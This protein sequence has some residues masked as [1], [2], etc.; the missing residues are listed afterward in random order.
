MHD[1]LQ[2][3]QGLL[4]SI[5][6][7]L[8]EKDKVVALMSD[9]RDLKIQIAKVNLFLKFVSQLK[10]KK[11]RFVSHLAITTT[12]QYISQMRKMNQSHTAAP[13]TSGS[14]ELHLPGEFEVQV[15]AHLTLVQLQAF[16]QDVERCLRSLDCSAD[17]NNQS[18][19]KIVV[20]FFWP[21]LKT[22][23]AG[24]CYIYWSAIYL[25]NLFLFIYL[26]LE[27]DCIYLGN[28]FFWK[29]FALVRHMTSY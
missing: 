12:S 3:H 15:A 22:Y 25:L 20:F 18:W 27:T 2:L 8:A 1:G 13:P 7:R 6:L 5:A 9:V 4:S 19:P 16:S 21:E 10:E 17:D 23:V 28:L 29:T 11:K 14:V 26:F 24:F